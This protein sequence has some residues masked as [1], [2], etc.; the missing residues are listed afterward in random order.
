MSKKI[1]RRASALMMILFTATLLGCPLGHYH[2]I[3]EETNNHHVATN[4]SC[5]AVD[6]GDDFVCIVEDYENSHTGTAD[7]RPA[8]VLED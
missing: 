8:C 3:D 6:C 7:E 1:K 2:Q 4:D 5:F